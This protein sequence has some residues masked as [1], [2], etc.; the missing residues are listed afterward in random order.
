MTKAASPMLL[1]VYINVSKMRTT[2]IWLS[3]LIFQHCDVLLV[4]AIN[5]N[6]SIVSQL[7]CQST[8]SLTDFLHL[9]AVDL[10]VTR[11]SHA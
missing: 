10:S 1:V 5:A 7:Q 11:T 2:H 8:K 4:V 9:F 3:V 6:T